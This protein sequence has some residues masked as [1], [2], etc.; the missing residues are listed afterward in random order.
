M[1]IFDELFR[2]EGVKQVYGIVTEW[3][4][5]LDNAE[6][7]YAVVR[8]LNEI[9][10]FFGSRHLAVDCLHFLNHKDK[11]GFYLLSIILIII[12]PRNAN[13]YMIPMCLS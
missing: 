6:R 7:K 11:V 13:L 2:S 1:T 9:T 8:N 10:Q 12:L 5:G 4:A 3:L